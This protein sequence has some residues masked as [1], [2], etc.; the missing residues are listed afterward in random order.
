VAHIRWGG[1][2]F[3]LTLAVP[4]IAVGILWSYAWTPVRRLAA[5]AAAPPRI[6]PTDV[7]YSGA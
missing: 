4:L 1:E 7:V 2:Y 5:A 3:Y 6:H